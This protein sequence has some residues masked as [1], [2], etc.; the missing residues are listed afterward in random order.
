MIKKYY[1]EDPTAVIKSPPSGIKYFYATPEVSVYEYLMGGVD[2]D[3]ILVKP[4]GKGTIKPQLTHNGVNS[5]KNE[6]VAIR[7][8]GY[9]APEIPKYK[10][11]YKHALKTASDIKD[12]NKVIEIYNNKQINL[13]KD[14]E[15]RKYEDISKDFSNGIAAK[16]MIL[17]LVGIDPAKISKTPVYNKNG[18]SYVYNSL[19]GKELLIIVGDSNVATTIVNDSTLVVYQGTDIYKRYVGMVYVKI[20]GKWVNVNK[21]MLIQNISGLQPFAYLGGG[22]EKLRQYPFVFSDFIDIYRK[23]KS[24]GNI[25]SAST[26]GTILD[27]PYDDR[28]SI[29]KQLGVVHDDL[30]SWSVIIGDVFMFVPPTSIKVTTR[31]KVESVPLI[32]SKSS[33]QKGTGHSIKYVEMTCYFVGEQMLNGIPYKTKLNN[34]KEVTYYMNGLRQLIAQF[35]KTPILPI[36]NF[37]LNITHNIEMVCLH[38]LNI[39]SVPGLPGTFKAEIVMSEFEPRV[40]V[41][42]LKPDMPIDNI[43]NWKAYR[44]Y[45]QQSFNKDNLLNGRTYLAPV[46]D[47]LN[48]KL[49]FSIIPEED[50]AVALE[51]IKRRQYTTTKNI[52]GDINKQVLNPKEMQEYA[53]SN[54]MILEAALNSYINLLN[55]IK[56]GK[57]QTK[58]IK[59]IGNGDKTYGFLKFDRKYNT[60]IINLNYIKNPLMYFVYEDDYILASDTGNSNFWTDENVSDIKF[61][62][63][64]FLR[65][66][67]NRYSLP[68]SFVEGKLNNAINA[69]G[70][71]FERAE[72]SMS[73]VPEAITIQIPAS[74]N[75][76]IP[77]NGIPLYMIPSNLRDTHI[78]LLKALDISE[79]YYKT[80]SRSLFPYEVLLK[81]ITEYNKIY[82]KQQKAK[83]NIVS[84]INKSF[85]SRNATNSIDDYEFDYQQVDIDC[86]IENIRVDFINTFSDHHTLSSPLPVR[87]YLGGQDV[88][89]NLDL[90]FKDS[91]SLIEFRHL[92]EYSQLVVRKYRTLISAG[93][94]KIHNEIANMAGVHYCLIN[95]IDVETIPNIV[96]AY[97]A[98]VTII[99]FDTSQRNKEELNRIMSGIEKYI[100]EKG[101][102]QTQEVIDYINMIEKLKEVEVYPDLELP[103]VNELIAAGFN[104]DVNCS[105]YPD[106]DFYISYKGMSMFNNV[107]KDIIYNSNNNVNIIDTMFGDKI[108]INTNELNTKKEIEDKLK[109]SKI[110]TEIKQKTSTMQKSLDTL[111]SNLD[112]NVSNT[113][114]VI[115]TYTRTSS[116]LVDDLQ[117]TGDTTSII[118]K[119]SGLDFF[120]G[121]VFSWKKPLK[122]V[123]SKENYSLLEKKHIN[124][125]RH[126]G[127]SIGSFHPDVFKYNNVKDNFKFPKH[128]AHAFLEK[129]LDYHGI[130]NDKYIRA[131]IHALMETE[132]S[133]E[134]FFSDG[135]IKTSNTK[136]LMKNV[137]N[138]EDLLNVLKHSYGVG[139][140]QINTENLFKEGYPEETIKLIAKNPAA[141]IEFGVSILINKYKYTFN[142]I[143]TSNGTK[144]G[145]YTDNEI[146]ITKSS[147]YSPS[148]GDDIG[149]TTIGAIDIY[150]ERA[151]WIAACMMYKGAS[152]ISQEIVENISKILKQKNP[153]QILRNIVKSQND[154]S[155]YLAQFILRMDNEYSKAAIEGTDLYSSML[156]DK[157]GIDELGEAGLNKFGVLNVKIK[158]ED[159]FKN[160]L[161]DTIKYDRRGR[162]VMAFPTFYIMLIDEGKTI[163]DWKIHDNFYG[164]HAIRSIDVMRS[165]KMAASTCIVEMS[166]TFSSYWRWDTQDRTIRQSSFDEVIQSYFKTKEYIE[167][168]EAERNADVSLNMLKPGARLHVRIGYTS[169]VND[170]P[171][172]FNGTITE[173]QNGDI[174]KIIAQGDGI[175]LTKKLIASP[176]ETDPD[177]YNKDPFTRFAHWISGGES[178][179]RDAILNLLTTK[180]S[181]WRSMFYSMFDGKFYN[182][183]PLGISH[184]GSERFKE[185]HDDGEIAQN[186]FP[187]LESLETSDGKLLIPFDDYYGNSEKSFAMYLF[188]KSVWD[189]IT[190]AT[191]LGP[192]YI[193]SVEPFEFRSTLFVGKG[194]YP[195]AYGYDYREDGMIAEKR[196]TFQQMHVFT[197]IT[198]IL[199]NQIKASSNGVYNGVVGNFTAEGVGGR[200][201]TSQTPLILADSDIWPEVTK[202][203][204]I[205]TQY[206]SKGIPILG[207]LPFVNASDNF[208][209][210][211]DKAI[212]IATSALVTYMKDMYQGQLTILGYPAMKP[213]DMM[214]I[215]DEYNDIYGLAEVQ[216]VIH[217]ISLND[218]YITTVIP[219]ACVTAHDIIT[220]QRWTMSSTIAPAAFAIAIKTIS[221]ITGSRMLGVVKTASG[222]LGKFIATDNFV[223]N[224][225]TNSLIKLKDFSKD[226]IKSEKI[227]QKASK[228]GSVMS[229]TLSKTKDAATKLQKAS[230]DG[231]LK[232]IKDYGRYFDDLLKGSISASLIIG[233]VEIAAMYVL[234]KCLI[235]W[236][237]RWLKNRQA[238]AMTLLK[239]NGNEI[240]A[241]I[242][243]HAGLVIGDSPS[244][245]DKIITKVFGS[246]FAQIFLGEDVKKVLDTTYNSISYNPANGKF[247]LIYPTYSEKFKARY[248]ADIE[249]NLLEEAVL[250]TSNIINPNREDFITP[251]IIN[252]RLKSAYYKPTAYVAKGNEL[253]SVLKPESGAIYY[254]LTGKNSNIAVNE[255]YL[256]QTFNSRKNQLA[257]D[258]SWVKDYKDLAQI[259]IK[260]QNEWYT[261]FDS[262]SRAALASDPS[263]KVYITSMYRPYSVYKDGRITM[264]SVGL[265]IDIQLDE[266]HMNRNSKGGYLNKDIAFQIIKS[267][268]VLPFVTE[269][270][271]EDVEVVKMCKSINGKNSKVFSHSNHKD[272]IHIAIGFPS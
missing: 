211:M 218:G 146:K 248:M 165:R 21:T 169:N 250:K 56:K 240:A 100:G 77:V 271:Y 73:G 107:I 145:I 30:Y 83:Q 28:I 99:S 116:K 115:G 114:T 197:S 46:P 224:I 230:L 135:R 136:S 231:N 8:F 246:T 88:V 106:P 174:V 229:E 183:H 242:N 93:F 112:S 31:S 227:T 84:Q 68:F 98:R 195:F 58:Y 217:H 150:S 71:M 6:R 245:K 120:L 32:R 102:S 181:W 199:D 25:V 126:V 238:V 22:E 261:L 179:P 160:S 220:K 74:A 258:F 37:Y 75:M 86:V 263:C 79:N 95:A 215:Y 254:L 124:R 225:I 205:D 2:G 33:I 38:A 228:Y 141:N 64:Y 117:S 97:K 140:M 67:N 149:Y 80:A 45:I 44:Y 264:H 237:Y 110:A 49:S 144:C 252:S 192:D 41:N 262:I 133:G 111:E 153:Y 221:Y 65:T 256:K 69:I 241:G 10:E 14:D 51:T 235:E 185:I 244:V 128:E 265:A 243:G 210:G 81:R 15:K 184:F 164:Y 270:L 204:Q 194:Y 202:I 130:P 182:S 200:K 161:H 219:D 36:S 105:K 167:S 27:N 190:I 156:T 62:K 17:E 63:K 12:R 203:A 177:A 232:T 19:I 209:D 201:V 85:N 191:M 101:Y 125:F 113:G 213:Y 163:F 61:H 119:L 268:E 198:D 137:K 89:I 87:Q 78:E 143:K 1:Y 18:S 122:S 123:V 3:T 159:V 255:A 72:A 176:K 206:Y 9:D 48:G 269:V 148:R 82:Q 53:S 260:S 60:L 173:L 172:V 186:I 96:G 236:V 59:S 70:N 39:S 47:K 189:V 91:A 180:G 54:Y 154:K 103:T 171:I 50:L 16:D 76:E 193:A 142:S 157:A 253:V 134:H 234:E 4:T 7:L 92:Y 121:A 257:K 162:L 94:M 139:I 109:N 233:I 207:L 147:R 57:A 208:F 166:N 158:P 129:M 267:I 259:N 187:V 127:K 155:I 170:M 132:S 23:E 152:A 226:I 90:I 42:D 66:T 108:S 239:Q 13:L 35:K 43:Y 249:A 118:D 168:Q 11:A 247:G 26:D 196:K 131:Y 20:D 188:N 104:V 178:E 40:F 216:Q 175:E 214:Y 251:Q 212:R 5:T 272:H 266:K 222:A 151:R 55:N 52:I 34:G 223:K 138:D 29:A 24:N